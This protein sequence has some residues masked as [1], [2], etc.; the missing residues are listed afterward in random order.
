MSCC[1]TETLE[2]ATRHAMQKQTNSLIQR[3]LHVVPPVVIRYHFFSLS[4]YSIYSILTVGQT[5]TTCNFTYQQLHTID[6]RVN[7]M[8]TYPSDKLVRVTSK[9][10]V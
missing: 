10:W 7:K 8:G 1:Q 6:K 4:I 5:R 2:L 3:V 9:D